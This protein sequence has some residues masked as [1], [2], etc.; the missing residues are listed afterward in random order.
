MSLT[1][2]IVNKKLNDEFMPNI[3]EGQLIGNLCKEVGAKHHDLIKVYEDM[4]HQE[5]ADNLRK[6]NSP[7]FINIAYRMTHNEAIE[8]SEKLKELV[9]DDVRRNEF[10][11]KTG[12]VFFAKG[13]HQDALKEY[14]PGL[15]E[16]FSIC[17]GYEV[18]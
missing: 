16:F 9:T 12:Y 11:K 5:Q 1:F 18:I 3:S 2:E 17:R 14:L 15:V 13:E 4:G 10:F 8:T 6:I 7:T